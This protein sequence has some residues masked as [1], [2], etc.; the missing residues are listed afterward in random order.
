MGARIY[1]DNAA[2]SFPKPGSVVDAVMH[3]TTQVPASAG[4][5]AYR[6]ARLAGEMLAELRA[7]I[8]RLVNGTDPDRVIFGLNGTDA[9]NLAI[10]GIVRPGDHVVTT[11]MDHNSVLRP[12]A[13][14]EED[15]ICQTTRV[16]AGADG[17]VDAAAV[18][19]A[20]RPGTRLVVMTHASNV[21]GGIQPAAEVGRA[22]R[23]RG[24]AFLLDA[25]QTMGSI[26]VDVEALHVDLLA[27]PGHKA[28]MGP[29]GTGVL[30]IRP[31][32]EL[33]PLR[34]GG[35][36]S[37][38][39]LAVQPD[40]LPDRFEPGAHNGPGLAGLL[41]A[42]KFLE[43]TGVP[44][45][46]ARKRE[47]ARGFLDVFARIPGCRV[48]GPRDVGRRV[49]IFSV[50]FEGADPG[51]VAAALDDGYEIKVRAGLH[52]APFAHRTFGTFESGGSV[53]FSPGFFTTDDEIARTAE[54][55]EQVLGRVS[56]ASGMGR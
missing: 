19:A 23:E 56:A 30:W 42:V 33:S 38:S 14:L 22:A 4:R 53:R 36:G 9:L 27:F 44:A 10:K 52:C 15:G 18:R 21:G 40:F 54:A 41:A 24:A 43:A 50:T 7:R 12:L 26:P 29:Q 49:P 17:I 16:E 48:H 34:E 20:L 28:V 51:R 3:Y 32:I 46:A 55:L 1:L 5:G 39:D 25:A 11:C 45:I 35:T 37:R 2:T 6:E 8:C 47:I 31:G 13:R